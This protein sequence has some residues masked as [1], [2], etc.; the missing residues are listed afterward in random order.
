LEVA[1]FSYGLGKGLCLS[2][3]VGPDPGLYRQGHKGLNW[4]KPKTVGLRQDK[5]T[6]ILEIWLVL[7]K[8]HEVF[9]HVGEE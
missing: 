8:K 5:I 2:P 4:G 7:T 1:G 3:R 6:R 9:A